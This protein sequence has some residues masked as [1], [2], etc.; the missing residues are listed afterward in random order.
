MPP[1]LPFRS[2]PY[3]IDVVC[4]S[5]RYPPFT[6]FSTTSQVLAA[7][8]KKKPGT[9]QGQGPPKK[10]VRNLVLKKKSRAASHNP[11]HEGE[12][13]AFKSRIILSNTNAQEV[14]GLQE[15]SVENIAEDAT[16]GKVMAIP[17]PVVDSLRVL[18]AFKRVQG[19]SNYR[20]PAC[21]V[22][23]ESWNLAKIIAELGN[24]SH[25]D[26]RASSNSIRRIVNGQRKSGKS[27]LLLQA[28]AMAILK[29]WVVISIP[30]CK[31]SFIWHE[32]LSD[33]GSNSPRTD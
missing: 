4:L 18:G 26:G 27:V 29:K 25:V 10:G 31:F 9:R 33:N 19:W 13:K 22:T 12:R 20:R 16:L 11:P 32:S 30:E 2:L 5:R 6:P 15:L 7:P 24:I 14:S 8:A 17:G 28:M 23:E 3:S 1:R 21:L